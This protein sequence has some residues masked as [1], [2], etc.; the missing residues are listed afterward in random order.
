LGTGRRQPS[1][2]ERLLAIRTQSSSQFGED[3]V[4]TLGVVATLMTPW[5][6]QARQG[7]SDL[8]AAHA[9]H[10]DLLLALLSSVRGH[11]V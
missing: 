8:F 4:A 11:D 6:A 2:R 10:E 7:G 9:A 5:R 3:L 1:R